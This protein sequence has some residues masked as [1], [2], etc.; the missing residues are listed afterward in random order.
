[1]NN[2]NITNV[3][4]QILIKDSKSRNCDPRLYIK[5]MKK[6]CPGITKKEF[7]QVF[8]N[9]EELGLPCYDTVT[10]LRRKIQ[11]AH[12]ELKACEKVQDYR[13]AKEEKCR[14]EYKA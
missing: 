14:R 12:P 11:A 10:R 1:M 13:A 2:E 3:I 8:M 9:L 4:K 7:E 6:L 5:V